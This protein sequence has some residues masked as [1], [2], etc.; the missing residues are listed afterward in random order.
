MLY[1]PTCICQPGG[2]APAFH[3]SL[4]HYSDILASDVSKY[5]MGVR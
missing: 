5:L 4:D 2:D 3:I 1:S